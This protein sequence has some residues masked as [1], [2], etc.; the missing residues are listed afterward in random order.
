MPGEKK[1]SWNVPLNMGTGDCRDSFTL[2][3]V[4]CFG[5]ELSGKKKAK[6]GRDKNN[7]QILYKKEKRNEICVHLM[8]LQ[9][10]T[11]GSQAV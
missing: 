7:V 6:K 4:Q 11:P 8:P 1:Q 2:G 5:F 10:A 3:C 9:S